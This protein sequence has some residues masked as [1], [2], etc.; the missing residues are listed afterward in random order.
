MQRR[1][2]QHSRPAYPTRKI[3][4]SPWG[5]RLLLVGMLCVAPLPA[6]GVFHED[7]DGLVAAPN[8]DLYPVT[9]PASG[10]RS[11][12]YGDGA[13]LDY[14]LGLDVTDPELADWMEEQE[15]LLLDRVDAL[16]EEI[17]SGVFEDGEDLGALA[18]QI[19]TL[20]E[21]AFGEYDDVPSGAIFDCSL[22]VDAFVPSGEPGD[23]G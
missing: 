3:L 9:L 5:A 12:V 10:S 7:I 22:E 4:S 20:L 16:L 18:A 21:Q 6:C 2:V 15:A 19:E 8:P 23:T 1:K 11:L 13:I 14:H 17:G